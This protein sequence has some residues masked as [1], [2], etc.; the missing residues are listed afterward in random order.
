MYGIPSKRFDADLYKENKKLKNKDFALGFALAF[1]VTAALFWV[2]W[3]LGLLLSFLV[4]IAA[5]FF[6]FRRRYIAYGALALVFF[7][8]VIWAT[9]MVSWAG[10]NEMNS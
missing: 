5:L 4:S 10:R 9:L 2:E 1:L 6:K 7:P 3:Y 8:F